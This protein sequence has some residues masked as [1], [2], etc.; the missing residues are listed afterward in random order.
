MM[1]HPMDEIRV[2]VK[3]HNDPSN[4]IN[5]RGIGESLMEEHCDILRFEEM[6]DT[7]DNDY[8][9]SIDG[10]ALD[11]SFSVHLNSVSSH[12]FCTPSLC[13]KQQVAIKSIIC[14]PA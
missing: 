13:P 12:V 11:A 2:L 14:D 6:N 4:M 7:D 10:V 1:G 3:G 9:D 5:L 8:I